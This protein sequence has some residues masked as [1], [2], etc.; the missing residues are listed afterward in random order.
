VWG[1]VIPTYGL[2]YTLIN[3]DS[4]YAVSMGSATD[5]YMVIPA[6]HNGLPVT[7]IADW[8]FMF[9]DEMVNVIIPNSVT[10]I[11]NWAFYGCT[12]LEI[13]TL[14]EGLISIGDWAFLDCV[15]MNNITIPSSVTHIGRYAFEG[16]TSLNSIVIPINVASIGTSAFLDCDNLIIYA[17]AASKPLGWNA[18]WNPSNRPV[19]WGYPNHDTGTLNVTLS[20]FT[21]NAVNGNTVSV[22]WTTKSGT[23]MIGFHL[24]RKDVSALQNA[25]TPALSKGEGDIADAIR[26]TQNLIPATN[27]SVA[28]EYS[29]VD[30]RV[31]RGTEYTYWLQAIN[32]DGSIETFGPVSVKVCEGEIEALLPLA[33]SISAVYPNPLS[34]RSNANFEVS[35]KENETAVLQIFNIKGQIVREYT[36]LQAGNHKLIWNQRD[37]A[38]RE[39]ASGVYFYRL[40]SESVNE[41]RRMVIIK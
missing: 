2:E 18:E 21:A 4:A 13:V 38:S 10:R 8:G 30:N 11:G 26:I 19:Y 41:V 20:S 17:E 3:D 16:C 35:V 31:E 37:F 15:S 22:N 29:F 23:S 12:D 36:G 1:Y 24:L 27:T 6:M 14:T 32:S 25:L 28:S 33:T 5:I 40:T 39:V 9:Y 7:A 34:V